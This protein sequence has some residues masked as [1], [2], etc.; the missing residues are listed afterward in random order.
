MITFNDLGLNPMILQALEEIGFETPT[1]I[2][3]ETIPHLINSEKDLV[4][5]AQTGT[6]KTAAFSLPVIHQLDDNESAVQSLILC[7][8]RE[9]AIQ[10]AND[11]KKFVKY[12]EGVKVVPV[13]GGERIDIQ[14]R[15]LKKFPQIVVG[16]PGRIHDLIRRKVLKV[17]AIKWLVLD[18][19]DEMLNMGFKEEL[20]AILEN[21][22]ETK[23]VLLFSATMNSAV[24]RIASNYMKKPDDITVGNK[25]S[26]AD[27]VKHFYYVTHE[28]DRYQTLRRI[29]DVNPNIHGIVFCRTRRETQLVADKLIQDH[30]SAEAIH[31]EITQTQRTHVMN[32]FKEKKTQ[33]LVATDVAARGIDVAGLT[34][35]INY[36]LPDK[37]ESYV[38]RSGRT[39]RANNSGVSL[40]IVNMRE[41][42]KVRQLENK[43]GKKF[44][45]SRIPTGEDICERQLFSLVDKIRDVE[46]NEAQIGKYLSLITK[47]FEDMDREQLIKKFVSEEFNRFLGHYQNAVDLNT[48]VGSERSSKSG[49]SILFSRFH[50]HV[51]REQGMDVKDLLKFI[52]DA[53]G[54]KGVEIGY[55]NIERG[56]TKF[57]VD[58]RLKNKVMKAF[59]GIEMDGKDANIICEA[60]GVQSSRVNG[61][62]GGGRQHRGGGRR[63]HER[64]R[65]G[66]GAGHRGRKG[67]SVGK[68][69]RY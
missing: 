25:N 61:G 31:G 40:V 26:G 16:T 51:G 38:H 15:A 53:P 23:Q 10:I 52:N 33:I 35:V 42:Y 69:R 64:S 57:E 66:G 12:L 3:T 24:R 19:A 7:P 56:F 44:E 68:R 62:G 6:G 48:R 47:K 55:I 9:L 59:D 27:N 2:Q 54:L 32:R 49:S 60:S 18:E 41:K 43:V 1:P 65:S 46:V 22:P 34:H 14:I 67:G 4:A 63:V 29:A 39:G 45:Q 50:I 36:N 8:T 20:D 13:Y 37:L 30:Y 5:L 28:K 11:I 17:G 58:D 21:T